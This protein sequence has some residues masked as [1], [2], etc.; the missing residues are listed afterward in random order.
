MAEQSRLKRELLEPGASGVSEAFG[1]T[2]EAHGL[3]N[4]NEFVLRLSPR[5]HEL[6][7][8]LTRGDLSGHSI[9]DLFQAYSTFVHETIHWWQHVGST[10]GLIYS[11]SYPALVTANLQQLA[12]VVRTVGPHKSLRRWAEDYQSRHPGKL[13]EGLAA[14]NAAVNNA[15]DI[16]FYKRFLHSP[17]QAPAIFDDSYFESVGHAYRIAYSD[18]V[19]AIIESCDIG[20]SVLPDPRS[21]QDRFDRLVDARH[22]NFYHGS[23]IRRAKVGIHGLFEGQARFTQLQF[24]ASAGG[25]KSCASYAGAGQFDGIYGVAFQTFLQETGW[26]WPE[27]VND[28][29]VALF[30]LVCDLAI[31]PTRGIPYDFDS[32]EDFI[33]DVDPGARFIRLCGAASTQPELATAISTYSDQEY[34]E[35]A[36][37]LTKP[38]GYDDPRSA[39]AEI[40]AWPDQDAGIAQ[41]MRE[42]ASFAYPPANQPTRVMVSHFIA[43]SRDKLANPAFFCWPGAALAGERA[44]EKTQA[45]FAR[46]LSLFSDRAD[47]EQIFVRD[48]PG[49][50]EGAAKTMLDSFYSSLVM[51]ELALQWILEDGPF[52]YEFESLTGRRD[53]PEM[54]AWAKRQFVTFFGVDPDNFILDRD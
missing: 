33:I 11:L 13:P 31:N 44:T 3:Y 21:W 22:E 29:I 40:A 6:V 50:P 51:Y 45:L 41:L 14:A 17:L 2:L 7:D 15:L 12:D 32:I 9:D 42:Q 35:V 39:L 28:P 49:K 1:A 10:T 30:L 43:F 27:Q 19:Q 20:E 16:G 36:K 5:I 4:T 46:H 37:A 52:R 25:E 47:T 34:W 23:P 24:L 18:T 38:C 8:A 53:N 54:E 48:F 26:P